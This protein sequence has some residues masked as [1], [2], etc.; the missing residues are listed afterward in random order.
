M[1]S[2]TFLII[3]STIGLITACLV[4]G[5]MS[6]LWSYTNTMF[7]GHLGFIT[8]ILMCLF[9]FFC[10]LTIPRDTHESNGRSQRRLFT[11]RR[12]NHM[13]NAIGGVG[14]FAI[15]VVAFSSL[16]VIAAWRG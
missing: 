10:G 14:Y 7:G 15:T 12:I 8:P 3:S 6:Y 13:R 11:E 4:T 5:A 16:G 2:R 1:Q 9:S